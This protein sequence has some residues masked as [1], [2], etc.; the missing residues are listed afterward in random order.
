M[1]IHVI[2]KSTYSNS[3][4]SILIIIC[5]LHVLVDPLSENIYE[6]FILSHVAFRAFAYIYVYI[7]SEMVSNQSGHIECIATEAFPNLYLAQ[8]IKEV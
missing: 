2:H 3:E 8:P 1:S 4:I 5:Y 7:Y 6:A